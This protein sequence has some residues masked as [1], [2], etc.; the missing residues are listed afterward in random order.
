MIV[1]S[2]ASSPQRLSDCVSQ[3]QMSVQPAYDAESASSDI[4]NFDY[5]FR[6]TYPNKGQTGPSGKRKTRGPV[7]YECL[8]CPSD[9]AWSNPKRDNAV[10]HAKN[11]HFR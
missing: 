10:Y 3:S 1:L 5:I 8:L 2:M 9:Q 4:L 6:A 11:Q 7:V